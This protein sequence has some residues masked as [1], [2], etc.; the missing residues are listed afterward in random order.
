MERALVALAVL[1]LV[2]LAVWVARRRRAA[3]AAAPE[4]FDPVDAGLAG[5]GVRVALLTSPYCL[6]CQ[7]WERELRAAGVEPVKLDVAAEPALARRYGV[8]E[9]PLVLAVRLPDGRVLAA[10]GGDPDRERVARIAALAS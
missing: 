10:E 7:A 5:E 2:A 9:T 6:A 1:A 3:P 8:R 4:R